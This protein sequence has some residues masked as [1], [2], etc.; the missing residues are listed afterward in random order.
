MLRYFPRPRRI[1][2]LVNTW[3]SSEQ[4]KRSEYR[5]FFME[6]AGESMV[7]IRIRSRVNGV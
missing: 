3:H 1:V 6:S 7:P 4:S 2:G 5:D